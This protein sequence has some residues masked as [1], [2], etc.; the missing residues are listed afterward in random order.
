MEV[1]VLLADDHKDFLAA[2]ARL[3]H[4]NSRCWHATPAGTADSLTVSAV[5]GLGNIDTIYRGAVALTSSDPSGQLPARITA[6]D[7]AS[8]INDSAA[9]VVTPAPANHF[10][11]AAPAQVTPGVPFD[12]TVTALDPYGNT[13]TNY[14]GS[15]HFSTSDTDPGVVLLAD[16]K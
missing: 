2:A 4:R 3:L 5:D 10:A 1:D 16:Y 6:S 11:L 13:D 8:G 7:T 12:L 15:M 9:V 14:Q